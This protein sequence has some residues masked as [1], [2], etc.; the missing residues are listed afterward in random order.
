FARNSKAARRLAEMFRDRRV[1]KEYWAAV[2][3]SLEP[4]AGIWENW[5]RKVENEAR[6]EVTGAD[7]PG[8][9]FARTRFRV[10]TAS[11]DHSLVEMIP[12]TGRMH[13][14]RLQAALA[15]VPVLG[16]ALYGSSAS[17]G[18]PAE[19]PRD[20]IIAL[21]A[22][23]LTIQHPVSFEPLTFTAPLPAYWRE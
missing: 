4:A 8:A 3:G 11:S 22:R 23:R 21:H 16:D 7:L 15:G 18:P 2:A 10:L 6:A 19:S 20:R 5:L 9:R 13:Q 14:L 17:F 12:E 1:T